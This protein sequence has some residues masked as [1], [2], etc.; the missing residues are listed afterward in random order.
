M[1]KGKRKK[2][3][4]LGLMYIYLSSLRFFSKHIYLKRKYKLKRLKI[5]HTHVEDERQQRRRVDGECLRRIH[6]FS[7]TNLNV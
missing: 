6:T 5:L 1:V 7:L 2:K 4:I 3:S